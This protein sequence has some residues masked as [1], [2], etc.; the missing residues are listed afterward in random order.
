M[1]IAHVDYDSVTE[2]RK[3]LRSVLD[4]SERGKA[5]T[6]NRNASISAVVPAERLRSYFF[7]TVSPRAK[8]FSEDGRWVVLLEDR[9]FVSEGLTVDDAVA[10]LVLSLREYAEDWDARLRLAP[11]HEQNWALVQLVNLSSDAELV[12]WLEQG[13]E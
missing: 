1:S 8:I 5:V 6:I 3:D 4:A 10:D 7:K 9:P 2:A 13:G 12:K 11:N